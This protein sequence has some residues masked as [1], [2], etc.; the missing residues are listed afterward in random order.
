MCRWSISSAS[1]R[2]CVKLLNTDSSPGEWPLLFSYYFSCFSIQIK[3]GRLATWPCRSS[4]FLD[5]D[6][7]ASWTWCPSQHQRQVT[8]LYTAVTNEVIVATMLLES[9]RLLFAPRLPLDLSGKARIWEAMN[10]RWTWDEPDEGFQ[11]TTYAFSAHLFSFS[12]RTESNCVKLYWNILNIYKVIDIMWMG[13]HGTVPAGHNWSTKFYG[14]WSLMLLHVKSS[15]ST[16]RTMA[17]ETGFDRLTE[18]WD[19]VDFKY[20]CMARSTM[21]R[22]PVMKGLRRAVKCHHVST[23]FSFKQCPKAVTW[24]AQSM[25]VFHIVSCCRQ[26]SGSQLEPRLFSAILFRDDL[27]WFVWLWLFNFFLHFLRLD[28]GPIWSYDI[29][30]LGTWNLQKTPSSKQ[31]KVFLHAVQAGHYDPTVLPSASP[32]GFSRLKSVQ[33]GFSVSVAFE[34]CFLA[35]PCQKRCT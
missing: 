21:S 11:G 13:H 35:F 28:I 19:D 10:L 16:P 20:E 17:G 4:S 6:H 2:L 26:I 14:L 9:L 30:G 5:K 27:I 29:C 22:G 31:R 32:V 8:S 34:R 23:L 18:A 3:L 25:S 33:I 24:K 7:T 1:P 12:R 15:D